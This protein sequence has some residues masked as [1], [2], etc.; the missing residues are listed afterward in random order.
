M[1]EKVALWGMWELALRAEQISGNPFDVEI[2]AL[3]AKDNRKM[4]AFGFY[5]GKDDDGSYIFKIRFM[6]DA[7][8]DWAYE[9]ISEDAALDGHTGS[10]NCTAPEAGNHG[11]ARVN[12]THFNYGDGT[13]LYP[14]GTTCYAWIHQ[15]EA[16]RR[17]T[18]ETLKKTRFKKMRMC[19]FPKSYDYNK[20]EPEIYPFEGNLADGFDYTRPNPAFYKLLDESVVEMANIGIEVDLILFHAYDRWGFSTMSK[21]DNHRY[22]RY[23]VARLSAYPNIWWS[24]ANEYDLLRHLDIQAWEDF[25]KIIQEMDY[26]EHLT[27]IHNC[28]GFYNHSRNWVTHCSIQRQDVYKT[29]EYTNEWIAEYKKP[30]VLDEI[31]YEGDISWGWGNITAEELTRRAWEGYVRGGYPGHGE[32]YM[33]DDE[34]LW[35]SKGGVLKGESPARFDFMMK[36]AEQMGPISYLPKFNP[37]D[38]PVG[39]VEGKV[40]LAYFG[41]NR[42]RFRDFYS[43][44]PWLGNANMPEGRYR[45]EVI[46]TWD[47][48]ITDAGEMEHDKLYVKLPGKQYMAVRLT[49]IG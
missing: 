41:F 30:A 16:L 26:V 11:V 4:T 47:M 28:Y 25:A 35:W 13:P 20:N 18:I 32:T 37:W 2:K 6:P 3:F 5:D 49:K 12:G 10:F 31:G 34:V 8:G 21:E 14:F 44:N 43:D 33:S 42:P 45:V 38:L 17:Q 19:V 29:T 39:G 46:D 23:V 1:M 48:T 24:L 9:T 7:Q 15:P 22:L 27:S 36:I 40:Y